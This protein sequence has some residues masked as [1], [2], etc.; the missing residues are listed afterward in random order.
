VLA[1]M[2]TSIFVLDFD[3][4]KA[5]TVAFCTLAL[6]QMWHV[7][8]M[9]EEMRALVNNEITRNRWVWGALLL[10]LLLVLAAVYVPLLAE[11]LEL[12]APGTAGW[13]LIVVSSFVP[14]VLAPIVRGSRLRQKKAH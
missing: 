8:N 11:V 9:R 6:A 7:L 5:V 2:A 14:L 3:I 13:A 1:A 4:R 12:S 10:C